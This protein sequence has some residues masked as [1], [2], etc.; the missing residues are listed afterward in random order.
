MSLNNSKIH[1]LF[2][3]IVIIIALAAAMILAQS[4]Y[5]DAA[6]LSEIRN[7]IS[8]KQS[9]L[10][11]GKAEE[12]EIS[13]QIM[14]LEDELYKLQT[15]IEKGESQLKTLESEL[16]EAQEKVDVQNGNLGDRLENMYKS[17]SVGFLD[18]LLD[19]HSFSEFLTNLDLVRMIYTSDMEVLEGLQDSYNEIDEKKQKI[20]KLQAELTASKGVLED[21]MSSVA[22]KKAEISK[23]N[24]ETEAMINEMQAEADRI[25]AELA[26]QSSSGEISNS[27]TSSYEGAMT[28]PTPGYGSGYITSYYGYRIHPIYGYWK[29]HSGIDIGAP[30]NARIVAAESGKVI[31]TRKYDGGGYGKYLQIDHG[32]GIVTLYGH[33]NSIIVNEGQQVSRG[34]TIAYVGTTGAST[35]NHLHFEVRK[36]GAY[37]DPLSYL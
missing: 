27:S 7:S 13:A 30:G 11:K 12:S 5:V 34:Q 25:T 2:V 28:W 37:V 4:A 8:E 20:E 26:A 15:E 3:D 18:V 1:I 35:G 33:C 32:G 19:S 10:E 23:E 22:E 16:K 24:A 21:E 14:E 9:Q 29:F 36:N 6:S 31:F 17:G